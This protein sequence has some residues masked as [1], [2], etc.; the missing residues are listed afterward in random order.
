MSIHRPVPDLPNTPAPFCV[1]PP[2]R[3]DAIGVALGY[4]F[5]DQTVHNL[6]ADM[7]VLL[8]KLDRATEKPTR[9]K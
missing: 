8:A 9:S 4:A 7:V 2:R 1:E 6:S 5:T 3:Q